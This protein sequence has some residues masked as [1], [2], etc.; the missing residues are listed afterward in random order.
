MAS[1]MALLWVLNLC[2]GSRRLL[3]VAERARLP[4]GEVRRAA[5]ALE[6]AGLLRVELDHD[7]RAR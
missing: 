5:R 1:Q 3:D 4:F 2:D 7:E 6:A